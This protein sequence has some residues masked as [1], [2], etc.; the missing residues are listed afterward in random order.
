M[1]RF[2]YFHSLAIATVM[3]SFT[4]CLVFSEPLTLIE[5][6]QPRAEIIIAEKPPRMVNLA[7]FELQR[8]LHKI[9]KTRL[10]IV[11]EPT[12][13]TPVQIYVGRSEHTD[14]LGV[15]AEGLQY[16]A[17]RIATGENW[18]TLIGHDFDYTPP[19]PYPTKRNEKLEAKAKAEWDKITAKHT[20]A[21][22]GFPY[23]TLYK[24]NWNK[25]DQLQVMFE[26]YGEDNSELW[27]KS[28]HTH[29]KGGFWMQDEG[30]SLNAV[31]D[32]LRSLGVRWFMPGEVGEV[33]PRMDTVSIDNLERDTTIRPDYPLR[34]ANWYNYSGFSWHD[35]I[36]GRIVDRC[37]MLGSFSRKR[38]VPTRL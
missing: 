5:E 23:R 28:D 17:Y 6:G 29:T 11:H 20:D 36:W 27:Q 26:G 18:L 10:P 7:A 12:D 2:T 33:V 1:N 34:Y 38:T 16:G 3:L 15:N 24:A 8:Y 37:K 21:A 35:V 25:S 31:Y 19:N 9:T 4:G 13:G 14:K 32:L 30:G 22:W